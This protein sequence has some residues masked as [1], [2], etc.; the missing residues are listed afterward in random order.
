MEVNDKQNQHSSKY[1]LC[2][3]EVVHWIIDVD[4]CK[5]R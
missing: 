5:N 1:I 4:N 2:L 3:A